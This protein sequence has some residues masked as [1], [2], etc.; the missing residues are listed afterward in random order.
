MLPRRAPVLV[1]PAIPSRAAPVV[2]ALLAA[3]IVRQTGEAGHVLFFV[4]ADGNV[5]Q[6]AVVQA[7]YALQLEKRVGKRAEVDEVVV[8][9]ALLADRVGQAALAAAFDADRL[10]PPVLEHL[11]EVLDG[12]FR[13]LLRQVGVQ[14][15]DGL[16]KRG[17][18]GHQT[19]LWLIAR[20]GEQGV[21]PL[22]GLRC[23]DVSSHGRLRPVEKIFQPFYC[24]VNHCLPCI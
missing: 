16:V 24:F 3:V 6:Y 23:R 15:E 1:R 18:C 11:V 12:L 21:P 5:P 19:S 2:A 20:R 7:E 22:R 14:D 8:A 13:L 17:S 9:V 4:V 10:G